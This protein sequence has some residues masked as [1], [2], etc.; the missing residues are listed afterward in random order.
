MVK[1]EDSNQKVVSSN[2]GAGYWMV[3]FTLICCENC[4]V[5]LKELKMNEKEAEDGPLKM[6]QLNTNKSKSSVG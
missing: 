1:G 2:P 6:V 3:I 4:I 5:C